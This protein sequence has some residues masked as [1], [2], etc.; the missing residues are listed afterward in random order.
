M[1]HDGHGL[2]CDRDGWVRIDKVYETGF[3]KR[4]EH[5]DVYRVADESENSPSGK[6]KSLAA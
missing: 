5:E 4:H 3:S 2:A 6:L 1:Q